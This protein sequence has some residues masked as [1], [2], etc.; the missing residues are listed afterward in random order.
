ME[1]VVATQFVDGRPAPD[2]PAWDG[3]TYQLRFERRNRSGDADPTHS[4][5]YP[6]LIRPI[7]S[8]GLL[9][10]LRTWAVASW[11]ENQGRNRPVTLLLLPLGGIQFAPHF[12]HTHMWFAVVTHTEDGSAWALADASHFFTHDGDLNKIP[13]KTFIE[14]G[15]LT[16]AVNSTIWLNSGTNMGYFM[17][18]MPQLDFQTEHWKPNGGFGDFRNG[19]TFSRRDGVDPSAGK[20]LADN[21]FLM[22][23]VPQSSLFNHAEDRANWRIIATTHTE[24][25]ALTP[26]PEAPTPDPVVVERERLERQINEAKAAIRQQT[27]DHDGCD[28]GKREFLESTGLFTE[29]E[30]D[31]CFEREY[32]VTFEATVQYTVRAT[33]SSADDARESAEQEG[34]SV[35]D[36]AII[37]AVRS[38]SLEYTFVDVEEE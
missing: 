24:A 6:H 4:F 19:F 23:S 22:A 16:T 21:E 1:N 33:A 2:W 28:A 7:R 29:E 3:M 34:Y 10:P 32:T 18:M 25:V 20:W 14:I 8:E 30:I 15:T 38:D 31:G 11:Y 37:S 26:P 12:N 27:M 35:H 13:H 17:Q 36:E 5:A 9:E